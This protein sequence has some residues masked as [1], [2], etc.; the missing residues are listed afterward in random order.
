MNY[1]KNTLADNR[2]EVLLKIDKPEWDEALQSA[3]AKTKNKYSVQGFRAGHA[4]RKVIEKTYGDTVFFDEAINICFYKNYL[5]FLQKEKTVHPATTPEI[6]VNKIDENGL[7]LR[8]L[9]TPKPQV[10]LGAYKGMDIE[11]ADFKLSEEELNRDLSRELEYLRNSR[12]KFVEVNRAAQAGD[13]ATIDFEGE[14]DGVKFDG[15][16][17][18][19]HDLEI[20]TGSFIDNF[21]DQLIGLKKGDKKAVKVTFPANYHEEKFQNKPAT[22]AVTI[23]AVKE[24]VLP[25]LNDTFVDEVSEFSTLKELKDS[26]TNRIVSQRTKEKQADAN[27]KLI[28]TIV[29]NAKVDIPE[30]MVEN[31][32]DDFV[33]DFE[34]RLSH[35]GLT[36]DG[37]L[38]YSNISQNDFRESRRE[39]ARKTV[40]TRLV[41]EEIIEKENVTVTD[42]D[43]EEK[44]NEFQKPSKKKSAAAVRKQMGEDQFAYFENSLLLNKLMT[45]LTLQNTPKKPKSTKA[46]DEKNK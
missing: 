34:H 28:E 31:Q 12:V 22:F 27:N 40:K 5:E 8:L 11:I 20:G 1:T 38:K 19:D 29:E 14:I 9:I 32:M 18:T 46:T 43:I 25:E 17:A 21:E 41:L 4:P 7:E 33:H 24:K 30:I 45:F 44:Y 42:A 39:D 35:Q 3:Y 10:T 16:T 37:Y 13:V 15:G 36:L 2:L 23:K 26:L 6:N